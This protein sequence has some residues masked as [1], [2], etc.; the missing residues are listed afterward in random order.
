[1]LSSFHT[2]QK[3]MKCITNCLV[4]CRAALATNFHCFSMMV[5]FAI[6]QYTTVVNL[7]FRYQNLTDWQYLYED[8]FVTFPIFITVNMTSPV[9]RLSKEL[10]PY[11]FFSCRALTSMVGQFL[12]QFATQMAFITYLFSLDMFKHTVEASHVVYVQTGE[13]SST[14]LTLATFVLTNYLYLGI[15]LSTS[16]SKPFRKPFYTN[17]YYTV[18]LLAIWLY[19]TAIVLLPEIVPRSLRPDGI[20]QEAEEILVLAMLVGNLVMVIMYLYENLLLWV[21]GRLGKLAR[22]PSS[23][24]LELQIK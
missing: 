4:V 17:P 7:Y 3:S 9:D 16:V 18:T 6:V 22:K 5:L 2:S 23:L 11:S 14:S 12:I 15:V 8:L 24:E 13:F 19:N 10:P 21:I 20:G 1:M